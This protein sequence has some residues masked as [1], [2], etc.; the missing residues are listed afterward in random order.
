[1]ERAPTSVV[2]SVRV[3]SSFQ[4][5][6]DGGHV[7]FNGSIVQGGLPLLILLF[8]RCWLLPKKSI[9]IILK[10]CDLNFSLVGLKFF[11]FI[12]IFSSSFLSCKKFPLW[13]SASWK[14]I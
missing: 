7:P 14:N 11:I 12:E 6:P 1:M 5:A 4:E 2:N 9:M 10:I 8:Q 3:C 13:H